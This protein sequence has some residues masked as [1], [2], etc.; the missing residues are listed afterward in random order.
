MYIQMEV[1]ENSTLRIAIDNHLCTDSARLWRLFRE[2][3]KG[4]AYIHSQDVIHRDLKPANIFLNSRGKVKIG[5]F[6]LA[7]TSSLALQPN[8]EVGSS[9]RRS[10]MSSS[11]TGE[12]GTALYVAPE[13]KGKASDSQ[14]NQ[15]VDM[16][17]LGII[18][19]EMC[20][21]PFSTGM[22]RIETLTALRSPEVTVP[23]RMENDSN[24]S[25]KVKVCS[26]IHSFVPLFHSFPI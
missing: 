23:N 25:R 10:V 6:G 9:H 12:V 17:S 18:F 14:H 19:F 7:T 11:A 22:E 1:C 24:Y 2:I 21:P 15:K 4:L 16:Y 13:L 3:T 26:S 20:H 8:H 5:D